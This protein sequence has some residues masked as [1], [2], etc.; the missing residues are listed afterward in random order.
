MIILAAIIVLLIFTPVVLLQ[1]YKD[2][3]RNTFKTKI[4]E[5]VNALV[6]FSEA[7]FSVFNNFP[8]ITVTLQHVHVIGKDNFNG[9]TLGSAKGIE[10][11]LNLYQLILHDKTQLESI[12][13]NE[14]VLNILVLKNGKTNYDIIKAD[15]LQCISEKI[16]QSNVSLNKVSITNGNI[17]YRDHTAGI[18]IEMVDVNHV[19]KGDF[20]SDI[21]DYTS[22]T[23]VEQFSFY[24]GPVKYFYKKNI[25]I[26]LIM[27]MNFRDKSFTFKKNAFSINQ[28]VFGIGGNV[29]IIPSGCDLNVVFNAKETS[30]KNI[31]SLIPGM[32]ME[33]FNHIT[34]KGLMEFHGF[35]KGKYLMGSKILPAFHIEAKVKDAMF[36]VDTL[37]VAVKNIQFDLR[38]DNPTGDID[39]TIFDLKTFQINIDGNP[40][41]GRFKI[42]GITALNIDTDILAQIDLAKL[43]DIYPM[44]NVALEGNLNLKLKAKGIYNRVQHK[45]K[46][47]LQSIP[48]FHLNLSLNN[49]KVKYDSVNTTFNNIHFLLVS[50]NT[51]GNPEHTTVDL[52]QFAMNMGEAPISGTMFLKG[53]ESYYIKSDFKADINLADI[54]NI[55]PLKGKIFKGQFSA[56]LKTEGVYDEAKHLF[57]ELNASVSLTNGYI[58]TPDYAEP[59]ENIHVIANVINNDGKPEDTRV[60]I[61]Q[62]SYM[63][64]G[65]PFAVSGYIED[66]VKM[67]Y[68]FKIKGIFD[69]D[70][71][72]K[73]YPL[74]G[75]KVQGIVSVDVEAKGSITDLENGN[76]TNTQCNGAVE[77][78]NLRYKSEIYTSAITISNAYFRLTPSK[79]IMDK[80]IGKLGNSDISLKGDLSNYMFFITSN[81]DVIKGDLVLTSDS[82]DLTEWID[83]R[84]PSV[85][86]TTSTDLSIKGNIEMWE[87]PKNVDFMFDS[88]IKNMVYEDIKIS[89]MKGEITIKNGIMSISETGFNSLN[90]SFGINGQYDT[91][92]IRHPTFDC[93]LI[94]KELD[95]NKAYKEIKLVRTLAPAAGNTY[96]KVS[97]DYQIAGEFNKD[98]TIKT[99]TLLGNGTIYVSDAKINGM[100]M[101]D[102]IGRSAK[103]QDLTNPHLKDFTVTTK[104]HDNKL[105]VDPFEV[106]VN[107]LNTEIEGYNSINGGT[108]NYVVKIEFTPIEKMRIPFH[109]TGTY[110]DPKVAM[111]K[112]KQE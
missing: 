111:G 80:C 93:K 26:D 103:K 86:N 102:E 104:I 1:F 7:N 52:K 30:F 34:T 63:M 17:T 5:N 40:I 85:I 16:P 74:N 78:E 36:K 3:I 18:F 38:I 9:D 32:Y 29:A 88:D 13:L 94:I 67:N 100:K 37:P 2:T 76:Y 53:F 12:S 98:F 84:N 108:I 19:S 71:L 20:S 15:T 91:R 77:I 87:V 22:N 109:V 62:F 48:L 24:D 54:E 59:I 46:S 25:C 97:I 27:E 110:D 99:E 55:Y 60:N 57:P 82:L 6:L 68:D 51:S 28:F 23:D 81:N 73:I 95:I 75:I 106:K 58:K 45:N 107:G 96:G 21:F 56:N 14:P 41:R 101:F 4:N 42:H 79:I 90:A 10:F 72:T 69:L 92:D 43:K 11:E 64:E 66:F 49:G 44:K 33:D 8:N 47:V 112:G 39:S 35:V 61:E 65:E 31:L 83:A 50:N 89:Q 70:K 105:Y